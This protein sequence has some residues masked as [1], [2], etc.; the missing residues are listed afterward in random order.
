MLGDQVF[1]SFA[2]KAIPS[3]DFVAEET[4]DMAAAAPAP[5]A[6]PERDELDRLFLGD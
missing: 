2:R 3:A 6:E 1:T 5:A 4:A